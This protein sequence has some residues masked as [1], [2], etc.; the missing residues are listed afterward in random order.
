MPVELAKSGDKKTDNIA[1][2]ERSTISIILLLFLAKLVCKSKI[3]MARCSML[4]ES[5][6]I[7]SG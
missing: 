4:G 5:D 3:A 6:S 1:L 2:D 7:E